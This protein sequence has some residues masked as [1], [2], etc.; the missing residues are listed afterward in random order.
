MRDTALPNLKL[1]KLKIYQSTLLLLPNSDKILIFHVADLR[2]TDEICSRSY[3][4]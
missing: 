3:F 4:N 1:A 2:H